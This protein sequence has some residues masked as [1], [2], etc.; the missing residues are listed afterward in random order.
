[1]HDA[2]NDPSVFLFHENWTREND[3]KR[4]FETPHIKRWVELTKTLLAEPFELTKWRKVGSRLVHTTRPPLSGWQVDLPH[5]QY[6]LLTIMP[7]Y[8]D[9]VVNQRALQKVLDV[10]W[11]CIHYP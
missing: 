3:P 10:Q 7:G 2:P 1:M 9:A 4:H 5:E 11:G 6:I 8:C